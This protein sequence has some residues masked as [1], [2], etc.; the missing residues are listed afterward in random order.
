MNMLHNIFYL[1]HVSGMAVIILTALFLSMKKD[2]SDNIRKK[3][4]TILMSAA[5]TQL[6]TGFALFFLLLSEVNHMKV[7]MKMLI[8]IEVAV[9]A[10][11]FRKK[12]EK[13]ESPN[14]ALILI[15]LSSAIA[16]A[17]IAFLL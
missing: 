4:S 17:M 5:H 16:V 6:L 8:A 2:I 9:V 14:P 1:L 15:I 3:I 13:N 11:I 12:I 7:G 10:S